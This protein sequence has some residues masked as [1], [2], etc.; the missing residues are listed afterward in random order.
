MQP[1]WSI[2]EEAVPSQSGLKEEEPWV[3]LRPDSI[4]PRKRMSPGYKR[5]QGYISQTGP[6]A[7]NASFQRMP[8]T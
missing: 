2:R 1:S 7:R 3:L 4:Q 5:I 8:V 6:R